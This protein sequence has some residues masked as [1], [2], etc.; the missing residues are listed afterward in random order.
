MRKSSWAKVVFNTTFVSSPAYGR[1]SID[2]LI[3]EYL[4]PEVRLETLQF[5]G[6]S[7]RIEVR[8]PGLDY[9]YPPHRLRLSRF[10]WHRKL[11]QVF[12]DFNLTQSEIN[13]L[14]RWEGTKSARQWYE[15]ERGIRVRDTTAQSITP[16]S[17]LLSPS[18]VVHHVSE[19]DNLLNADLFLSPT[20]ETPYPSACLTSR[21][22]ESDRIESDIG[23]QL[24]HE[25]TRCLSV[26]QN[27]QLVASASQT[28]SSDLQSTHRCGHGEMAHMVRGEQLTRFNSQQ[29]GPSLPPSGLFF[30][31][32]SV[33]S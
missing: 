9:S 3:M 7:N 13:D 20:E 28:Q 17:P 25:G 8:Y 24:A 4:V 2:A 5:Y 15:A 32:H 31:H 6:P 16:A 10:R 18:V 26:S 1:M 33:P 21:A 19:L 22:R 29:S 23:K 12:D 11:F 14:C 27:D 30:D